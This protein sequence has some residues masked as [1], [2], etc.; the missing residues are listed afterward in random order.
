MIA[1]QLANCRSRLRFVLSRAVAGDLVNERLYIFARDTPAWASTRDQRQVYAVLLRQ[2]D[3][4]RRSMERFYFWLWSIWLRR[5]HG[6]FR[7]CGRRRNGLAAG[8][9]DA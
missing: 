9:A 6:R 5:R 2:P 1:R 7:R 3:G 4:N 8:R